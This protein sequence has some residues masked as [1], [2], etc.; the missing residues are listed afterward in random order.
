VPVW[1]GW[2]WIVLGIP[3]R[4][5]LPR[6]DCCSRWR[7]CRSCP[8]GFSFKGCSD[9]S[10]V[11]TRWVLWPF[12]RSGWPTVSGFLGLIAS[13]P[14]MSSFRWP[15]SLFFTAGTRLSGSFR[16]SIADDVSGWRFRCFW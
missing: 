11:G 8:S 12:W 6:P 10:F 1:P 9:R 3:G 15:I 16:R 4:T 14:R 5:W 7:V 13:L 2:H